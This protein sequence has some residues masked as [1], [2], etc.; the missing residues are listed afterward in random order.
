MEEVGKIIGAA[1]LVLTICFL[2][3]FATGAFEIGYMHTIGVEK[4]N[5]RREIFEHSNSYVRGKEAEALKLYNEYRTTTDKKAVESA[6]RL[7]FKDFDEELLNS[8]ELRSF[9]KKCKYQ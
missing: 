1:F 3:A 6:V 4:E 9:V 5:A 8:G 2:L 7:M